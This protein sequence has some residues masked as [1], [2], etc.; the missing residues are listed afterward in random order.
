MNYLGH[1]FL[2]FGNSEILVGNMIGDH[3]KG[4]LAL[5]HYP[6]G[7]RKG[8]EL[9]RKI[10][11]FT[12][13]HPSVSR[14]KLIFREDYGLY[15]GAI[16]DTVFDHFLA[17]DPK[18]FASPDAL[19]QF[20]RQTYT[21]IEEHSTHLPPDFAAYFPHMREYNWLLGYRS[22]KGVERSLQGLARRAKHMPASDKAYTAFVMGYYH[23][24]QCYF[25]LIDDVVKMAKAYT[26]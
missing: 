22:M 21:Q 20:T 15:A 10:D 13:N 25:E 18:Y 3:V 6:D 26:L 14:A 8:I 12:D 17:N 2:S 9:H 7:I 1:A 16:T 24:N 19:L 5:Q 11:E 23:L 4:R